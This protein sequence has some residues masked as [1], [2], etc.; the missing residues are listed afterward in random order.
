MVNKKKIFLNKRMLI[1]SLLSK[2][3]LYWLCII[4][5]PDLLWLSVQNV[6]SDLVFQKWAVLDFAE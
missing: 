2:I 4:L 1:N 5:F 6:I 3:S